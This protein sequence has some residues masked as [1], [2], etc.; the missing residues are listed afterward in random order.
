MSNNLP[1]TGHIDM[2]GAI[3]N[4][5]CFLK[6]SGSRSQHRSSALSYATCHRRRAFY[7]S[8][9]PGRGRMPTSGESFR[10]HASSTPHRVRTGPCLALESRS[11]SSLQLGTHA[12]ASCACTPPCC[13]G[14]LLRCSGT[15]ACLD[16]YAHPAHLPC[17]STAHNAAA[18]ACASNLCPTHITPT[19][20]I[21]TLQYT[22]M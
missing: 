18:A 3:F 15:T 22:H 5:I 17:H 7:P 4:F 2:R 6:Y 21:Y 20:Y 16:C 1:T 10:S 19:H 9:Q 11:G 8:S 14:V 13:P 12:H